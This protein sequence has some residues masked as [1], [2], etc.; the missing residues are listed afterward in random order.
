MKKN[1]RGL[2]T[3]VLALMCVARVSAQANASSPTTRNEIGLVI[4]GTETPSIGL[5][6]GGTIH[7]NSSLAPG[8]EI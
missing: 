3:S 8:V 2:I 1:I 5:A 6:D 7:L 4:G